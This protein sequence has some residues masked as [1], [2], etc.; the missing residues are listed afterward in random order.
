MNLAVDRD[1][2]AQ[3]VIVLAVCAGAWLMLVQPKTREVKRL[4]AELAAAEDASGMATQ[5][6]VESLVAK[7][8]GFRMR[9]SEIRARSAV[10]E[11]TSSLYATIMRRAAEQ[12]VR[13]QSLQPAPLKEL[14]KNSPV[15]VAR[16]AMTVEGR[17]DDVARFLDSVAEIYAFIR[18]ASL[19][20]IPVDGQQP[21]QV[22]AR[23]GCDVLAFAVDSALAGIGE[24]RNAQ[25]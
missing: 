23:Y 5:E 25:P 24:T 13:V 14:G 17:Y 7:V 11:D 8:D 18:P 1:F 15:R 6:G 22:S 10:A 16:L 4:E 21:D 19:Q 2:I 12:Q 9:L 20:L 3:V